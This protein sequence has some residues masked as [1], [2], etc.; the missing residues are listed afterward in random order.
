MGKRS[1]LVVLSSDD[2]EAD[3]SLSSNRRSTRSSATRLVSTAPAKNPGRAKK[4][5]G[6]SSRSSLG[7]VSTDWDDVMI[8]EFVWFNFEFLVLSSVRN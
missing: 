2:D 7:S 5:R 4:A 3:R 8:C 6:L 1:S